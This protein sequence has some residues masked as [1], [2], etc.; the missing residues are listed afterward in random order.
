MVTGAAPGLKAVGIY[1]LTHAGGPS[2][3]GAVSIMGGATGVGA[4]AIGDVLNPLVWGL[5]AATAVGT[6]AYE[7]GRYFVG[8]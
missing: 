7:G 6:V 8:E 4:A 5:A 1:V 3:A 2:A